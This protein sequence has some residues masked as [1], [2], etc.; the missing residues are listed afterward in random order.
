[1]EAGS[2]ALKISR[3]LRVSNHSAGIRAITIFAFCVALTAAT[4]G[5]D[6]PPAEAFRVLPPAAKETPVISPYL[7]YQTEMAWKEDDQR[8]KNWGGI[9]TE[10]DLLRIQRELERHLLAM[11]GG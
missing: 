2:L 7:K 1:M 4:R 9:R 5:A 3:I 11:L 8:V 10:Q 6:M